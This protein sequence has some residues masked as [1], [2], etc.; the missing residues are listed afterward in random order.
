MEARELR[1]GN[2]VH[3]GYG[4]WKI[5]DEI[6]TDRIDGTDIE[7]I[8][9]IP[10]TPEILE[11]CGFKNTT[12]NHGLLVLDIPDNPIGFLQN[13]RHGHGFKIRVG[14]ASCEV[15]IQYLHQL[16]NLYFA[17]CGEEI[18]VNLEKVPL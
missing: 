18:T 6:N 7:N 13:I 10:L 1:I 16:Q 12:T 11:A 9:P 3:D 5:V 8:N 15:N 14:I 4:Y 17:L 2:W